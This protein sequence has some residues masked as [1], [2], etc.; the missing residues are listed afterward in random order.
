MFSEWAAVPSNVP[1]SPNSRHDLN[2]DESW[3]AAP[4][5]PTVYAKHMQIMQLTVFSTEEET[6][7]TFHNNVCETSCFRFVHPG[8]DHKQFMPA[9]NTWVLKTLQKEEKVPPTW[10]SLLLLFCIFIQSRSS[11]LRTMAFSQWSPACVP[12]R[13]STDQANSKARPWC[14]TK[15]ASLFFQVH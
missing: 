1:K 11:L 8:R 15:F 5:N 10:P 4:R 9:A 14:R 12:A 2:D 13:L 3:L 6:E 7:K